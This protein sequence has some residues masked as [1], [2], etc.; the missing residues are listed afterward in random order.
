MSMGRGGMFGDPRS[1]AEKDMEA[2]M[3]GLLSPDTQQA[4]DQYAAMDGLLAPERPQGFWQGGGK[5]GVKD[6]LAGLL[7]A[8]GDALMAQAGMGGGAVQ[9][10]LGGR[11]NALAEFKKR[12]EQERKMQQTMALI[13]QAYPNLSPAQQQAMASGVGDYADFKPESNPMERDLQTYQ[14]WD[15]GKRADYAKMQADRSPWRVMGADGVPY[16]VNG[17][18]DIPPAPVGE[19]TPLGGGT[20]NGVNR[21][22]VRR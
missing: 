20:G 5:F 14:G 2:R 22:P 16:Q 18:G 13:Q 15:E 9:G 1:Q 6:G 3:L 10:L 8:A 12:A 19:L 7:A 4:V 11:S 21:F 17:G